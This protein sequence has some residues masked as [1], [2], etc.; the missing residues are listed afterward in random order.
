MSAH[1]AEDGKRWLAA[2]NLDI[3]KR[4]KKTELDIVLQFC[5]VGDSRDGQFVVRA[6]PD[7][8]GN[9]AWPGERH[10]MNVHAV[11]RCTDIG[12]ERPVSVGG[13]QFAERPEKVIPSLVRLEGSDQSHD[14]RRDVFAFAADSVLHG[15]LSGG[16][17][18]SHSIEIYTWDQQAR[19]GANCLIEGRSKIVEG[20]SGNGIQPLWDFGGESELV[21]ILAGLRVELNNIGIGLSIEERLC[22]RLE[23]ADILLRTLQEDLGAFKGIVFRVCHRG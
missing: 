23:F 4:Y 7:G 19:A 11:G 12:D 6:I 9:R 14:F 20:V 15:R 8:C 1:L 16:K 5:T 3:S 13:R 21:D 17:G 10:L 22:S 2:N 18:K